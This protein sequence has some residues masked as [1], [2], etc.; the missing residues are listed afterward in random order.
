LPN[1]NTLLGLQ[2]VYNLKDAVLNGLNLNDL[3]IK[4]YEGIDIF[5][6]SSDVEEMTEIEVDRM[7]LIRFFS[8]TAH[9]DFPLHYDFLLVDVPAGTS[10]T[11]ILFYLT[12]LEPIVVISPEHNSLTD[13][14]TLLQILS[15]NGFKGKIWIVVNQCTTSHIAK[16]V[17]KEFNSI[18]ERNLRIEL[19]LLA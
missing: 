16:L 18:L 4:D 12:S 17:Y 8:K 7:C 1:I 2:P 14:H 9:H 11:V 3:I 10:K 6:A 5:P 19:L 15:L 13:A